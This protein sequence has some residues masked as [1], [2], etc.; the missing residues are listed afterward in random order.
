MKRCHHCGYKGPYE[1]KMCPN[2]GYVSNLVEGAPPWWLRLIAALLMLPVGFFGSCVVFGPV[3]LLLPEQFSFLTVFPY[4]GAILI[5]W[6]FDR[7][8]VKR[9]MLRKSETHAEA[10]SQDIENPGSVDQK[11]NDQ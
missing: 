3:V 6:G 11:E 5:P 2:C 1:R 7:L 8:L 10:S 4:V 9:E